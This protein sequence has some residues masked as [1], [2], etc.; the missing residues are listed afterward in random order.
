MVIGCGTRFSI[1]GMRPHIIN[2]AN[3][4]A[5]L[6]FIKNQATK[7]H[8]HTMPEHI[9]SPVVAHFFEQSISFVSLFLFVVSFRWCFVTAFSAQTFLTV[10]EARKNHFSKNTHVVV[11]IHFS[12][13]F[14][15]TINWRNRL[16]YGRC[17]LSVLL[18]ILLVPVARCFIYLLRCCWRWRLDGSFFFFSFVVDE[19]KRRVFMRARTRKSSRKCSAN[20]IGDKNS[21]AR[22]AVS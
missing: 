1:S 16:L 7:M 17:Y 4:I 10:C 18:W 6:K 12:I 21:S 3:M 22:A 2:G 11:D 14:R 15:F 19:I 5:R 8:R 13:F 9:K 20:Q